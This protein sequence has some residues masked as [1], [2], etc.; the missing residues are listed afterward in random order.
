M[1]TARQIMDSLREVFEQS[2]IQ[3][4]QDNIKYVYNARMKEDQSVREHVL[5]MIVNFNVAEM[6]GA[7]F[8]EKKGEVNV[9]RSR[10]FAPSSSG[11]KKIQKKKGEKWKGPIV[12]LQLENDQN[13]WILESEATNRVC[14]SLQETSSLKQLE[15]REMTLKLNEVLNASSLIQMIIQGGEYMDL[16][17]QDYTIEHGIQSQLSTP[18][19]KGGLFF[20]PQE[21]RVFVSTNVT[22]LEEDHIRDHKPR[23]KLVLNEATDESTRVVDVVSPSSR[24][25]EITTS[26]QSHP[27]QSLRMP[28]RSRRIVSQPNRYLDLTETQVFIPDNDV[29]DPLSYKQAMNDVNKDQL[30]KA[31]DLEMEFMYFN[32]VGAF[33]ST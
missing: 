26:G 4:K 10:R 31:M 8:D 30:V 20:N 5:D 32:S 3:M 6:N 2:S 22:F 27:S 24:V 25:D 21:N 9:A 33:R 28:R 12:A 19:T 18:E 7:I 14:S 11:S 1:V 13:A 15:E 16:R 29:K 23:S 17:F